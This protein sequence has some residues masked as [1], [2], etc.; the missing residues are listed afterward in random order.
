MSSTGVQ[1]RG[2]APG[3]AAP[4]SQHRGLSTGVS[5]PGSVLALS[6]P[7]PNDPT[8]VNIRKPLPPGS[9]VEP[10]GVDGQ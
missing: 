7:R 8:F 6:H 10:A 1:H 9:L 3:S 5:A 4:G 2:P